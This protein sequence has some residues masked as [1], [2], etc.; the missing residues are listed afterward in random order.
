MVGLCS[1]QDV[2]AISLRMSGRAFAIVPYSQSKEGFV[3]LDEDDH[4]DRKQA[5]AVFQ[6]AAIKLRRDN[7]P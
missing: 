7:W 5:L 6:D 4:Q 3:D 1:T 2:R